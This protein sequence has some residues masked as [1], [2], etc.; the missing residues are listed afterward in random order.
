MCGHMCSAHISQV[1]VDQT[2]Q[3][4]RMSSFKSSVLHLFTDLAFSRLSTHTFS[5]IL[6]FVSFTLSILPA[7]LYSLS[8]STSSPDVGGKSLFHLIFIPPPPLLP[9]SS[10][11]LVTRP[12]QVRKRKGA[13]G[14]WK[15]GSLFMYFFFSSPSSY[16]PLF[17]AGRASLTLISERRKEKK[18]TVERSVIWYRTAGNREEKRVRK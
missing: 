17:Y 8:L 13:C 1:T 3:H 15:M 2:P 10:S 7:P 4:R 18:N 16:I 12:W 14:K 9:P 5:L 6:L 11:N